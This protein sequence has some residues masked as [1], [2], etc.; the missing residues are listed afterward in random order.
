MKSSS[1]PELATLGR[2]R[3]REREREGWEGGK[4]ESAADARAMGG[5]ATSARV[6]CSGCPPRENPFTFT[7]NEK[8][9]NGG[10]GRSGP[11]EERG[12][13]RM[14]LLVVARGATAHLGATP[15][16]FI[17]FPNF[18]DMVV[19]TFPRDNTPLSLGL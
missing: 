7:F 4:I 15:L 5:R 8:K 2:R 14:F 13:H 16:A 12:T 6:P 3:Q 11:R 10:T 19:L 18:A 17:A 1:L 9:K